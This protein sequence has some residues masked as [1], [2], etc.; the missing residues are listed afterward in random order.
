MPA[1]LVAE[2]RDHVAERHQTLVDRDALLEALP[3]GARLLGT[4][5]AGK[6]HQVQ[7]GHDAL[8]PRS[9]GALLDDHREERVRA[10]RDG[11][12]QGGSGG[13]P[14][15][16]GLE[17]LE[18]LLLGAHGALVHARQEDAARRVLADRD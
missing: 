14:G 2:G 7:L 15:G 18:E 9:L 4:L 17:A 5:G 13:A 8:R 1:L 11:V 12:H 16:T 6:I 3:D 10:R